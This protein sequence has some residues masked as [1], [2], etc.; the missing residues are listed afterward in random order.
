[1]E[2]SESISS[3][4]FCNIRGFFPNYNPYKR[5]LIFDLAKENKSGIILLT[6]SH[7]N[8]NVHNDLISSKGWTVFRSDRD[9]RIC[10]GVLCLAREEFPVGSTFSYS[11]TL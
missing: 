2:P 8:K 4:I 5:D 1:M 11:T 9:K 3:I 10:G 6:E 7:W